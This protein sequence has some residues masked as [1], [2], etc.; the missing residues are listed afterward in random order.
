MQQNKMYMETFLKIIMQAASRHIKTAYFA[1]FLIIG[2]AACAPEPSADYGDGESEIKGLS[3]AQSEWGKPSWSLK[4]E[5]SKI[6]KGNTGAAFKKPVLNLYDRNGKLNAII[7]ADEGKADGIAGTGELYGHVIADAKEEG[8]KLSTSQL[9]YNSQTGRIWSDKRT[10]IRRENA[11]TV[12][13]S[14]TSN[15]DFSEIE[16]KNQETRMIN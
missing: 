15:L 10:E 14:F 11:I 1:V 4:A 8:F 9:F 12:G 7:T 13:Q 5:S 16:I 6:K 3:L 2:L